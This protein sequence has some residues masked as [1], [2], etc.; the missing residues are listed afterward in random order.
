[1]KRKIEK[2]FKVTKVFGAKIDID[3]IKRLKY[4]SADLDKPLNAICEEAFEDI[5][6]KYSTKKL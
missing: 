4:L 5:L 6:K 1:M 3:L 2:T